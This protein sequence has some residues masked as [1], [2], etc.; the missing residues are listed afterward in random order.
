MTEMYPWAAPV[1]SLD[2][3]RPPDPPLKPD[4]ASFADSA[5]GSAV[6][7]ETWCSLASFAELTISGAPV[8]AANEMTGTGALRS[9][10]RSSPISPSNHSFASPALTA[11]SLITDLPATI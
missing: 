6:E 7:P 2:L 1:L 11:L 4:H 8:S 5:V 10:S 3:S 9:L